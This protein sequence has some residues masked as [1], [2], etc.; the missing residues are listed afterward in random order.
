M[1]K[2]KFSER[3]IQSTVYPSEGREGEGVCMYCRRHLYMLPI[4]PTNTTWAPHSYTSHL[5][6]ILSLSLSLSQW[7][8]LHCIAPEHTLIH[9]TLIFKPWGTI[10]MISPILPLNLFH[11]LLLLYCA[12][13]FPSKKLLICFE[14]SKQRVNLELVYVLSINKHIVF[15]IPLCKAKGHHIIHPPTKKLT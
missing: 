2:I 15:H 4:S 9:L 10:Y 5:L 3:S 7:D 12:F 14:F 13:N 11:I 1:V 8:P 6:P